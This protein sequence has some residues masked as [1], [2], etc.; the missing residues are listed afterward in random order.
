MSVNIFFI[1]F[2]ILELST[3]KEN[4]VQKKVYTD[5][6]SYHIISAVNT[7][8]RKQFHFHELPHT[9]TLTHSHSLPLLFLT[10]TTTVRQH[11]INITVFSKY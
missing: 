8:N 2:F 6:I 7:M 1:Y 3:F 5:I 11:N 10:T 4:Y 9:H